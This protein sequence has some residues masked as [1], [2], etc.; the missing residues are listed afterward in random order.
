VLRTAP[1]LTPTTGDLTP[2]QPTLRQ[3]QWQHAP[4]PTAPRVLTHQCDRLDVTLPVKLLYEHQRYEEA[5]LLRPT[6]Q[7]PSFDVQKQQAR[8]PACTTSNRPDSRVRP[9]IRQYRQ[10]IGPGVRTTDMV[11][12]RTP[13]LDHRCN[14]VAAG[15]ARQWAHPQRQHLGLKLHCQRGQLSQLPPQPSPTCSTSAQGWAPT[16]PAVMCPMG[17]L[18]ACMPVHCAPTGQ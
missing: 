18:A 3:R 13:R 4:G 12:Y 5:V 7:Q 14:A 10:A 8:Q 17:R 6:L 15:P 9:H 11:R 2:P 1:S 16:G